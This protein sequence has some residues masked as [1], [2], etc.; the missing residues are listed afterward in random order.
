MDDLLTLEQ[1]T[2]EALT[3]GEKL[4]T[5]KTLLTD[6]RCGGYAGMASHLKN[7]LH[8]RLS[9]EPVQMFRRVMLLHGSARKENA[10]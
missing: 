8:Q 3:L 2:A 9:V 10:P 7:E 1:F 5:L 4:P 6:P